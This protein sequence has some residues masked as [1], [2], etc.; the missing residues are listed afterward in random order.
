MRE[1]VLL[2]ELFIDLQKAFNS[3]DRNHCI[4][5]LK[6]RGVGPKI[7]RLIRTRWDLSILVC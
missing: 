7:L 6:N 2:Y 3:M 1:Q 4:Q 5:I